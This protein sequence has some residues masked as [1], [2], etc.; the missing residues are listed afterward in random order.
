MA[1]RD[2]KSEMIVSV[3]EAPAGARSDAV[4][5]VMPATGSTPKRCTVAEC[6]DLIAKLEAAIAQV[7]RGDIPKKPTLVKLGD[8]MGAAESA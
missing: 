5:V 3:Y 1:V 8:L 7:E 2:R 4:I 6:R